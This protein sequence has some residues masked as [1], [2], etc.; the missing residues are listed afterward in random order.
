MTGSGKA[1]VGRV[2]GDVQKVAL[3]PNPSLPKGGGAI[4]GMGEKFAANPVTGTGSMTVPIAIS[5]GRSGFGPQLALSYDSG[6]GNGPFGLGW[7]LSLPSITRKTD[8]GLPKYEDADESDVFILSGAE[9]LVPMFKT[10]PAT[11]EFVEDAN[12]NCVYDESARD[13]YH[14]RRYRPRIEGLFARIER[15]TRQS[16]GDVYWRSISKDNVTTFY[17]KS[18][19]SRVAHPEDASHIFSWLICQSYDDKG[20]AIVY[21]YAEENDDNVDR[22]L[23]S[24]RNRVRTANRYLKRIKYGNRTPNRDARWNATDPT[25]LGD[26]MFEVVFDYGEGHYEPLPADAQGRQFVRGALDKTQDWPVRQDPFSHYRPGFDVRTYRLCER[27]LVFHHFPAEL[28]TP[29]CLV[30]STEFTY[31]QS[32]I[33][34]FITEITQAGYVRQEN[35]AYFKKSLPPLAFEYS[36]ATINEEIV[37]VDP[38]SLENLPVGAG[39]A[40]YQWLDLDGEGLQCVLAEQEDGWYYKRNVSPLSFTFVAG[41]PTSTAHFDPVTEVATL[42]SFAERAT[43]RHQFL[44]LA[45]DGQLDCVVLERPV[46]GFYERTLEQDWDAFRPLPSLPNLD[47]TSSNLRFVDLT[48]DGHADLLITEDEALVWHPALMEEGFGE[49]IRIRMP[50]DEEEGPVVSFAD[51][52]QAIFLADLSGDGLT[53]I[54]RIRNGEICYWPNL[55]YGRFGAKVTM[56]NSPG[57]DAP[58]QFDQRRVRLADIDGS[59]TTDVIYLNHN[60]VDIYR[61]QCGNGW[62]DVE[63]LTSIP[64]VDNVSSVQAVDLLGNGTA[65]L[66]WTSPLPGDARRQMRYIDLMGGQKPHLLIRTRNNLGA[67]TI[68]QYAPSTKFY[69]QDNL[70]GK[71]WVTRLPFPV[72]CVERVETYDRISGNR[73]VT[74][75]AYHHGYFDGVEREF[76]GFGMVEQRDTEEIGG[77]PAD[78]T[79][80]E[81]TNLDA[82]SFVPP[83]RTKTWFHTGVYDEIDEVSQHFAAEYYGAPETSDPEY[84]TKLD[85]FLKALLPDTVL[86]SGLTPDQEREAGRALKGLMLRQEV[87]ADDAPNGA[88]E[89]II[90]RARTPYTVIEQNFSIEPLQPRASNKHGV[91]FTHPREALSYHYERNPSDPRIGHAFTLE[92]DAFGNVLKSLAI[93]YGRLKSSTSFAVKATRRATTR[94]LPTT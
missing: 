77:V 29:D 42:P 6:A 13:G 15:W 53:D 48:G 47:W 69:L 11:G 24:E 83:I 1:D 34:S 70:D 28:G 59:G 52:S 72:H 32:P 64:P 86:P 61:N 25:Q 80:S 38:A 57:F 19:E 39:G 63:R 51:A 46:A 30:R 5:P 20:N 31:N 54:V 36:Q 88:S 82:A 85:A 22:A 37:D 18:E 79:S 2:S 58:D 43:Q 17:G 75:Y 26:W 16:D 49:A 90:R 35:G 89:E 66:V 40:Q 4:R 41:K 67:E 74:R 84:V 33:A 71:P 93:G 27:V 7:N 3:P 45:G 62:S 8:K 10:N 73:F 55:G 60:G 14:V 44:D 23:V 21:E 92:V 65:C 78:A 50:R 9:D 76:R 94:A 81:A 87:Y 12:G 91:F 56:D 68:V